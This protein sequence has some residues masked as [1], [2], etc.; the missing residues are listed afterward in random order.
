ARRWLGRH[1]GGPHRDPPASPSSESTAR[2]ARTPS[3]TPPDGVP[4][5]PAQ[6]FSAGTPLHTV[7]GSWASWLS[8]TF[9][10]P[11]LSTKPG[12]LQTAI[13]IDW[14]SSML[15]SRGNEPCPCP[16]CSP[17]AHQHKL[18]SSRRLRKRG[19]LAHLYNRG[20]N[21]R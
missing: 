13:A 16:R 9:P 20:R 2:L 5:V 10:T 12:Q 4:L 15:S 1:G 17:S 8:F 7:H 19:F 6:S 11:P 3:P 14:Q 21:G 18:D